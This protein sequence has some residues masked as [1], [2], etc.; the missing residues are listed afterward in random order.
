MLT[1]APAAV[2]LTAQIHTDCQEYSGSGFRE[3]R[4]TFGGEEHE[5]VDEDGDE[6][7]EA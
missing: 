1:D 5:Q 4:Q 7:H 3:T 6:T 2:C